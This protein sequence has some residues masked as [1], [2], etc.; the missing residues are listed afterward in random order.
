MCVKIKLFI[1]YIRRKRWLDFHSFL[2]DGCDY[3]EFA[4][5]LVCKKD[6]FSKRIMLS[7]KLLAYLRDLSS[8][9]GNLYE[10]INYQ[11]EY[12]WVL[13][14]GQGVRV[15]SSC[16]SDLSVVHYV[17]YERDR[18]D[19]CCWK[20]K[21][22]LLWSDER[23]GSGEWRSWR[24]QGL[25]GLGQHVELGDRHNSLRTWEDFAFAALE[26]GTEWK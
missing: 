7:F 12:F 19:L 18:L 10:I 23:K 26:K 21:A 6:L 25:A 17:L 20:R 16:L 4:L 3:S 22:F 24:P 9:F 14:M 13:V 8:T 1:C 11:S 15:F 2:N 5:V